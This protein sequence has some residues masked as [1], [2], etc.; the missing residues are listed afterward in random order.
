MR[1]PRVDAIIN[2]AMPNCSDPGKA[3]QSRYFEDVHQELAPLAR[4]L[5][6][7]LQEASEK[8]AKLQKLFHAH[9]EARKD[10]NKNYED[11]MEKTQ[12]KDFMKG[13]E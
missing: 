3:P 13:L 6:I 4:Q 1:T 12:F 11:L 8:I 10:L 2:R 5:E 7:E 9:S